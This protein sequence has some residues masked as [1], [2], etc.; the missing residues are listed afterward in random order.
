MPI[1]KQIFRISP[2]AQG[3]TGKRL[4]T[5]FTRQYADRV[6]RRSMPA[7]AL[8]PPQDTVEQIFQEPI[9]GSGEQAP[10]VPIDFGSTLPER[11]ALENA[12]VLGRIFRGPALKGAKT[13][14]GA[15]AMKAPFEEAIGASLAST[16]PLS[17]F[18]VFNR[19]IP[20]ADAA[21]ISAQKI[22]STLSDLDP[23][24]AE[25]VGYAGLSAVD[26]GRVNPSNP[27]LMQP[28]PET[29]EVARALQEQKDA[30]K[31]LASLAF[32]KIVDALKV[33]EDEERGRYRDESGL[34]DAFGE[35]NQ[36]GGFTG[37]GEYSITG[38][39]PGSVSVENLGM[40]PEEEQSLFESGTPAE[41][42]FGGGGGQVGES[43]EG[44]D[45]G[46][47]LC[48]SLFNQGLM[49]PS[50][51][52][53]DI[54]YA[55]GLDACVLDGYRVWARPLADKMDKNRKL[56]KLLTYPILQWANHMSFKVDGCVGKKTMI[57]LI[58][59]KI[60]IPICKIIG[61]LIGTK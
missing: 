49:H 53:R 56:T 19:G 40:T 16:V 26:E 15:L 59:E 11:L 34:T 60:G 6:F 17:V 9:P 29:L 30:P 43:G 21:R 54:K 13:L 46:T 37:E 5:P 48:T 27:S 4:K 61:K 25:N 20:M 39:T 1:E 58:G 32:K 24:I 57:G 12:S 35:G 28:S 18:N 3:L 10:G 36:M 51:Y 44:D 47:C 14:A 38:T 45:G 55:H 8:S 22:D 33:D 42:I 2:Q 50:I 31:N 41:D 7:P 52:L 23:S